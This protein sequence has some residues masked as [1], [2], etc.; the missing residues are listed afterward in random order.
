MNFIVTILTYPVRVRSM[1]GETEKDGGKGLLWFANS[2]RES[3]RCRLHVEIS[4]RHISNAP[5]HSGRYERAYYASI[6]SA[7]LLRGQ[8]G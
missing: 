5:N 6:H 3:T 2:M 8:S 4:V 7:F 1:A